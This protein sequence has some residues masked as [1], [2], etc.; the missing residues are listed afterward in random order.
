M[1]RTKSERLRTARDRGAKIVTRAT[2][3]E[4]TY[5]HRGGPKNQPRDGKPWKDQNGVRY[6]SP[7]CQPVREK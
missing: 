2:G 5:D 6:S 1:G 7:E 4:V 3:E